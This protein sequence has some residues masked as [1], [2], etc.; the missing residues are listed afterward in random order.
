MRADHLPMQ[1]QSVSTYRIQAEQIILDGEIIFHDLDF[2]FN[3]G[4]WTCIMGISGVGKTTLLRLI[5]GLL[6]NHKNNEIIGLS[7]DNFAGKIAYMAQED[8]LLPWLNVIENVLL[9]EHLRRQSLSISLAESVLTKIG[10]EDYIQSNIATLSGG[11][12]QRVSLARTIIE[13]KPIILMDEPF[14]SLDTISRVK[15]QDISFNALSNHT[16][17]LVTHDPLEAFRVG[18]NVVILSEKPAQF[19]NIKIPENKPIREITDPQVLR[20]HADLLDELKR[21][22]I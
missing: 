22:S 21:S 12:R 10:L 6:Q 9:G 20:H 13:N 14:S 7:G 8:L 15:M 1:N 2:E 19:R 5:A 3:V 16:V 17:L 4:E 11:M 18:H